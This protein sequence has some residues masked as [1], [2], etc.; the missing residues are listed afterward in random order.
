MDA[1]DA[2]TSA[3]RQIALSVAA[4][5]I[6]VFTSRGTTVLRAS[7]GRPTMPILAITPEIETARALALTWGVY[8]AAVE[9]NKAVETLQD[10]LKKIC[11]VAKDKGLVKKDDDLLVITAGLPF[12]TPGVANIIRIVPAKGPA[13]W[14]EGAPEDSGA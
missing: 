4:K 5:A 9:I 12:G 6:V 3:A 7:M 10:V 11:F 13:S 1:T 8:P 14:A 2:I